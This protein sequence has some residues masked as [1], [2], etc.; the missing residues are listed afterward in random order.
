MLVQSKVVRTPTQET[1]CLRFR[2]G[3]RL[4]ILT[5][6]WLLRRRATNQSLRC[7]SRSACRRCKQKHVVPLAVLVEGLKGFRYVKITT[8][9]A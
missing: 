8:T 1:P 6:D 9:V 2:V 5:R 7:I 3:Y 4:R